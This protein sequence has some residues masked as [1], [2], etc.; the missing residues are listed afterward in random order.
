MASIINT[1]NTY[2]SFK[3][4]PLVGIWKEKS[5][6]IAIADIKTENR[7]N[8]IHCITTIFLLYIY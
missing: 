1:D 4:F 6:I 3:D 7:H 2:I 5:E 8:T